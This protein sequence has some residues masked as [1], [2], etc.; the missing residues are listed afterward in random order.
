MDGLDPIN[1]LSEQ[2]PGFVWRYTAEGT[3]TATA[4]RP[5]GDD[6]I[7]NFGVWESREQLWDFVYRTEHL[8]FLR[9][10]R[11]WFQHMDEPYLVLW[12][13]PAGHIP[14]M[15]E[16]LAKLAE[17]RRGGWTLAAFTFREPF[18]PPSALAPST[19]TA[20]E[21]PRAGTWGRIPEAQAAPTV[22]VPADRTIPVP[23]ARNETFQARVLNWHA[24]RDMRKTAPSSPSLLVLLKTKR[25]SLTCRSSGL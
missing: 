21:P 12:W 20:T 18:D 13:V 19:S 23:S 24:L 22:S 14:S 25:T 9:R 5:F 15:A 1:A 10:R 2:A 16:A 6:V 4:A 7:V 8:D 3:N 11:E 17:I